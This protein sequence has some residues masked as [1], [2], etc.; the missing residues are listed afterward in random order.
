VS[1]AER[2]LKSAPGVLAVKVDFEAGQATVGSEPDSDPPVAE[3]L[4][5][6]ESIGYRGTIVE[7]NPI[8]AKAQSSKDAK[9]KSH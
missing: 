3:V 2:A 8:N 4:S 9:T 7:S 1:K 5:A 6:L